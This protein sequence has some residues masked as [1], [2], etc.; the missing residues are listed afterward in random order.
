MTRVLVSARLAGNCCCG[1]PVIDHFD[2]HDRFVSCER[3]KARGV[4]APAVPS[5]P[6]LRLVHR[7]S[8][9]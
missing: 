7:R 1:R 5:R 9:K 4:P 8:E 3:L 2:S 6:M